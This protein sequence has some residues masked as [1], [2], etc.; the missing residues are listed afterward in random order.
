MSTASSLGTEKRREMATK[1]RVGWELL[2][3]QD[4][5]HHRGHHVVH[6]DREEEVV[7]VQHFAA[8]YA[9]LPV[10]RTQHD[11]REHVDSHS[12]VG[13]SLRMKKC[14][15]NQ[16]VWRFEGRDLPCLVWTLWI[17]VSV[18]FST[19]STGW[20]RVSSHHLFPWCGDF[21]LEFSETRYKTFELIKTF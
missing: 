1:R 14:W 6:Q 17:R 10:Q 3:R 2:T 11:A 21:C 18:G 19:V 15:G 13:Q 7:V 8:L 12:H 16:R 20:S 4:G 9:G 5:E